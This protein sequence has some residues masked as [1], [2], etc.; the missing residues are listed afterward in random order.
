MSLED[1]KIRLLVRWAKEKYRTNIFTKLE[2]LQEAGHR[3][4]KKKSELFLKEATW[5]GLE[6]TEHGLKS[7]KKNYFKKKPPTSS[8][9]L[10][11]FLGAKRSIAK[12]LSFS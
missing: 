6:I 9:E 11:S 4:S 3:A 1:K 8:K 10:K 12:L 2:K 7:N 5:L